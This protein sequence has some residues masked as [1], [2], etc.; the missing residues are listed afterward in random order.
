MHLGHVAE[1]LRRGFYGKIDWAIIEVS[2]YMQAGSTCR[3]YLTSAGGVV[4]TIVRLAK[5]VILELNT[6]HS[7]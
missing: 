4:P 2:G 5:H 7:P 6:F 1:R 3:A